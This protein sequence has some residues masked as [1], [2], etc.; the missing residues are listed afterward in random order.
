MEALIIFF[1]RIVD[2]GF[3]TLRMMMVARGQRLIS[4]FL[5]FFGAT[6]FISAIRPVLQDVSD[7]KRVVAYA[8]GFAT[9][10]VV[11]MLAEERL[12]MGVAFLRII[13]SR[14]GAEVAERLRSSGYAVTEIPAWGRDGSV[15]MLH[16]LV[17]RKKLPEVVELITKTDEAAFIFAERVRSVQRGYIRS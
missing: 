6:I 7:W 4:W 1:L 2:V 14:R 17:Q 8:A 5:G 16:C 10:M 11:G 12:A 13:S 9:G 3:A 15:V